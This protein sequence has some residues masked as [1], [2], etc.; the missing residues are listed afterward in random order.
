MLVIRFVRV[1]PWDGPRNITGIMV[2]GG[3]AAVLPW[4]IAMAIEAQGGTVLGGADKFT[5]LFCLAPL[6]FT[7]AILRHTPVIRIGTHS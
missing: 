2:V 5:L 7:L 6:A 4:V 1:R 3:W